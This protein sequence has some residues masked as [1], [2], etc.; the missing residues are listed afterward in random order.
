MR[1]SISALGGA[2]VALTL[3][4]GP[5]WAGTS[6]E[7]SVTHSV[8]VGQIGSIHV[9][10]PVRVASQGEDA[11]NEAPAGNGGQ[12]ASSSA[13]VVQVGSVS[14]D[15]PVRVL[16]DGDDPAPLGGIWIRVR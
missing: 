2:L 5:A 1:R 7:P 15:T 4:T 14:T 16:S 11:S 13:G 12:A 10:A 8:A 9:G 3:A 6:G